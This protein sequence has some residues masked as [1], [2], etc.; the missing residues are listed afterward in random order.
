MYTGFYFRLSLYRPLHHLLDNGVNVAV[1]LCGEYSCRVLQYLK[2]ENHDWN[3]CEK[4]FSLGIS[5][6]TYMN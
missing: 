5:L 3:A 6:G 4:F 2:S 1:I